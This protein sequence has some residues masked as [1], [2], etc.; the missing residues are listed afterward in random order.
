MRLLK[1][2]RTMHKLGAFPGLSILKF[3][4]EIKGL[5]DLT[6]SRTVLDYGCG[7]GM[8]YQEPH[9]LQR[10]WGV[11]MTL[12]DPAGLNW[13]KPSGTFDGVICTDVLEHIPREEI[14]PALEEILRYASRFV[15]LTVCCRPAKKKLPSGENCH[16]TVRPMK[17]WEEELTIARDTFLMDNDVV[18][19][20]VLTE[21]P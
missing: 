16:V 5:I 12:Y 4:D 21:T 2:Y 3:A 15:F 17:W 19:K 18:A 14:Q 11:S 7:A 8:Q 13:R 10:K 1:D 6:G 9:A 20:I